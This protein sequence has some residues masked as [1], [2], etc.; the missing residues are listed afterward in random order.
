[1]ALAALVNT[2]VVL[3]VAVDGVLAVDLRVTPKL[4]PGDETEPLPG[5]LNFSRRFCTFMVQRVIFVAV[6]W[7]M[8]ILKHVKVGN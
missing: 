7:R 1:M 4:V 2:A 3:L 6:L 8:G 5:W